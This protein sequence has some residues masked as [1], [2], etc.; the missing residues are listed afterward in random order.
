[1]SG[2]ILSAGDTALNES[3]KISAYLELTFWWGKK[4]I[5]GKVNKD[6]FIS[7]YLCCRT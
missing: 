5:N 7:L 3:N 1:M 4:A 6:H 2:K